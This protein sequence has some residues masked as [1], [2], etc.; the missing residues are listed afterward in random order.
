LSPKQSPCPETLP[1]AAH[2]PFNP[3]HIWQM[4]HIKKQSMWKPQQLGRMVAFLC[5]PII[6]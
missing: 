2:T 1:N 4:W 3:F 6:K 5:N